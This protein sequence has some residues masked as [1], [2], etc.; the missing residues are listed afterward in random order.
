[1]PY[2]RITILTLLFGLLLLPDATAQSRDGWWEWIGPV[3]EGDSRRGR[4]D[5][6]GGILFPDRRD[7]DERRRDDDRN[8]RRDRDDD[9]WDDDRYDRRRENGRRGRGPAFCRSG[10]GHPVHGR[11]WCR[12][13]GFGLGHDDRY[14]ERRMERRRWEDVIF[15]RPH[16]T[17]DGGILRRGA[18]EDLLGSRVLNRFE[19]ARRRLGSRSAIEG[20][21]VPTGRRGTQVLQLRTGD[22]PLAELTDYEGDGRVDVVLVTTRR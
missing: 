2:A 5:R 16:R 15:R 6:G 13:K 7:R 14:D 3:F 1:M 22:L 18:L 10:E 19:D 11:Q 17:S 9:D 12:D 21:W 20:R 4:T 8:D